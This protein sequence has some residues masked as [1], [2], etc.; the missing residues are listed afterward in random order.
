VV[1]T[2]ELH[3]KAVTSTYRLLGPVRGSPAKEKAP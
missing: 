1:V 3:G 2:D